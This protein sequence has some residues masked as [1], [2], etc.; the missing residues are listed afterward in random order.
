MGKRT[1]PEW[2][3]ELGKDEI[4]V[5]G[6]NI[7]GQHGGGA[8]R[9]AYQDFGAG[10]G[11]GSGP[12]GRC[13][14]I[15]TMEGGVDYV[16]RYV[17]EFISYA[18]RHQEQVF[19]VTRIGC[20]IAGFSD[21]DIAPLFDAAYRLD[22]VALPEPFIKIIEENRARREAVGEAAI[23]GLAKINRLLRGEAPNPPKTEK[24]TADSWETSPMPKR[25]TRVKLLV[26]IGDEDMKTIEMGHI[27][28]CMEDKWFMYCEDGHIRWYRSWTGTC[29]FDAAYERDGEYTVIDSVTINRDPS[30]FSSTDD[31][32][33]AYL[34][35]ALMAEEIGMDSKIFWKEYWNK[36]K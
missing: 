23:M 25:T 21:A 19:L 30:Q 14:A 17:D 4:F 24:A 12:T 3:R 29:I 1:T 27:P 16:K 8:A 10:W 36:S 22:N 35:L 20:G 13:Y 32:A 33:D 18:S 2:I 34:F 15:P 9:I 11:V 28:D 31:E 7:Q 26:K 6:S 5:F